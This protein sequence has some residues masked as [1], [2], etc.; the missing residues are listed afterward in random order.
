V[1][2]LSCDVFILIFLLL[3]DELLSVLIHEHGIPD[4]VAASSIL[5]CSAVCLKEV[6]GWHDEPVTAW[7]E[8]PSARP[9]YLVS[10]AHYRDTWVRYL[11]EIGK[12]G[13]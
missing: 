7:S 1:V 3:S 12:L 4:F 10:P 6:D 13:D 2:L 11:F 8:A 9:S 5:A